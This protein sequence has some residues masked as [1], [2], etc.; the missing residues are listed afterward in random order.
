MRI[1]GKKLFCNDAALDVFPI[2]RS[3]ILYMLMN[4]WYA[5]FF[6]DA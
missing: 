1:L 4:D 2:C 3:A 5:Q 6:G